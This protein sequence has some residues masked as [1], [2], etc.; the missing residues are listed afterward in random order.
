MMI[1]TRG[2]M[3]VLLPL[4]MLAPWMH[5]DVFIGSDKPDDARWLAMDG[6]GSVW[7]LGT[8]VLA[9]SDKPGKLCLSQTS[10]SGSIFLSQ[11]AASD[12]AVLGRKQFAP[13][14]AAEVKN[15]HAY[16]PFGQ[17][18]K[19]ANPSIERNLP[20]I[21]TLFPM[22]CLC[23]FLCLCL[24]ITGEGSTAVAQAIAISEG[25]TSGSGTSDRVYVLTPTHLLQFMSTATA[26]G[27][28]INGK[29]GSIGISWQIRLAEGLG[30]VAKAVTAWNGKEAGP[31]A[32]L[33][34]STHMQAS[35][36]A[37]SHDVGVPNTA[38]AGTTEEHRSSSL[39]E[40]V[41][42]AW[43]VGWV[44]CLEATGGCTVHVP[45]TVGKDYTS[46]FYRSWVSLYSR[47][48]GKRLWTVYTQIP[49]RAQGPG[50]QKITG[51]L[52]QSG[53]LSCHQYHYYSPEAKTGTTTNTA[54]GE[55]FSSLYD[56]CC[57]M[58]CYD[59]V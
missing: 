18:C 20:Y 56:Y 28:D 57:G 25:G 38:W 39:Q 32:T 48:S 9:T 36:G 58:M 33:T 1:R 47:E 30:H 41:S 24:C 55:I 27:D 16:K 59:F 26:V 29:R 44:R 49:P 37:V 17:L 43:V 34:H 31:C 52:A 14:V 21:S 4:L 40:E 12:G 42:G 11:H 13:P 6:T 54:I 53:A 2:T 35:N 15:A 22:I 19:H 10:G 5:A 45:P 23:I 8:S 7:T 46:S 50:N 3:Q 51:F